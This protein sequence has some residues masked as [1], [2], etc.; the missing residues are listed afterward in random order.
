MASKRE[1]IKLF[2]QPM[3]SRLFKHAL[4]FTQLLN[5]CGMTSGKRK[6]IEVSNFLVLIPTLC[7]YFGENTIFRQLSDFDDRC[8]G[9]R[10]ENFLSQLGKHTPN[11]GFTFVGNGEKIKQ[12]LV[13]TCTLGVN[14][15]FNLKETFDSIVNSY[16]QT[17]I[18]EVF[19]I[20]DFT[21]THRGNFNYSNLTENTILLFDKGERGRASTLKG[22]LV[23]GKESLIEK[24]EGTLIDK[25]EYMRIIPSIDPDDHDKYIRNLLI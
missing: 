6:T 14:H 11:E 1:R 22:V 21:Y 10:R 18:D 7:K 23:N 24:M 25:I 9:D 2:Q 12:K 5:E 16:D 15:V 13:I 20:I 4:L 19:L 8:H 17:L 3:R